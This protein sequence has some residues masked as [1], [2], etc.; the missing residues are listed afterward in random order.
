MWATQDRAS[1][2]TNATRYDTLMRIAIDARELTGK[3]TGVGRYLAEL[4][5][6]LEPAAGATGHDFVLCAPQP[7]Q[8]AR[9]PSRSDIFEDASAPGRG[10]LWQQ[11]ALPRLAEARSGRRRVRTGV[12]RSRW[13]PGSRWCSAC[14]TCRSSPTRN[15]SDGERDCGGVS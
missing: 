11:F 3:P 4:S 5:V 6:R 8:A 15:G 12:C 2:L 1:G 13:R 14:T 10:T 9:W 7:I